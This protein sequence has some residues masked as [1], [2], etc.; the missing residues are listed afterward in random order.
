MG[1][2]SAIADASGPRMEEVMSKHRTLAP[3]RS[4][5]VL[6][7]LL[8]PPALLAQAPAAPPAPVA[9]AP[10]TR[11]SA[12]IDALVVGTSLGGPSQAIED[13]MWGAGLNDAGDGGIL[14]SE[15]VSYPRTH[16]FPQRVG[17][18]LAGRGKVHGGFFSWG[19][20][21]G[22]TGLGKVEGHEERSGLFVT[23]KSAAMS[24]APMAWFDLGPV[25]RL[26]V[27]PA[28]HDVW[29]ET[30]VEDY[31]GASPPED[32]ANSRWRLGALGEAAVRIP[33]GRVAY[34]LLLGQYRWM[35][36]ATVEIPSPEGTLA[37]PV[38]L[39]HGFVA[40]GLGT[41]F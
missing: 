16:E 6:V 21:A 22:W 5:T 27:G 7:L 33:V 37:V 39:S 11:S 30:G 10:V 9:A 38:R 32:T 40:V 20:G 8:F 31:P 35:Q 17:F 14:G 26:G 24:F 15:T 25:V 19:L 1:G 29:V 34:A 2:A 3:L 41:R 4:H 36:D 13:A 18:W 12:S 28:V 23:A